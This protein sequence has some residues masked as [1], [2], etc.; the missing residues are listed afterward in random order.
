MELIKKILFVICGFA[1]TTL[2]AD[3]NRCD[4][5]PCTCPPE[6]PCCETPAAPTTAAYNKGANIDVCGSWDF[7]VTGTFLYW[8]PSQEQMDVAITS[9]DVP[10]TN[11]TGIGTV[12]DF[13]FDWKPAFKIGIGYAWDYD[14]WDTYVQYTRINTNMTTSVNLAQ[15]AGN[16]SGATLAGTWVSSGLLTNVDRVSGKWSLN[17]NVID[18]EFGRPY[19]NGTCLTF[20]AHYGLKSGWIDQNYD[21]TI[22]DVSNSI[23]ANIKSDSWLIGPRTGIYTNWDL[24]EGFRFFGNAAASLF[25]QKFSKV[26]TRELFVSNPT[27]QYVAFDYSTRAINASLEM[28]LGAGWG[29]YFDRNNWYFDLLL[30]YEA[31]V[32]FNQNMMRYLHQEGVN[33]NRIVT[34]AGNLMFQG[35]NVTAKFD[36]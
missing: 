13:S 28:F 19:Y 29:T 24:G 8:Q 30:G 18:L 11:L 21:E 31:Q 3:C 9:F 17:H 33:S 12:H 20:K 14:N 23:T 4:P 10:P 1:I 22:S 2:S 5:D 15:P 27:Q 34:K 26:S 6:P 36:F 35:L 25:Y 32:F 7:Y 16:A